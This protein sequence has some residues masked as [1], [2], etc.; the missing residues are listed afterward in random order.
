VYGLGVG[1]VVTG[2][3][4]NDD[5]PIAG[6]K[7]AYRYPVDLGD[8]GL[9]RTLPCKISVDEADA[10]REVDVDGD[11]LFVRRRFDLGV[12]RHRPADEGIGRR[13]NAGDSQR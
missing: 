1:V 12:K 7:S 6:E 3:G 10:F 13:R 4:D 8:V 9:K 11:V 2:G 5:R